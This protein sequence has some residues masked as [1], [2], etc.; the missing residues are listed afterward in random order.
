MRIDDRG[1]VTIEASLALSSLVIVAAAVVGAMATM[2]AAIAAVDIAGAAARAH[3][4]GVA[5]PPPRDD[6]HVS[7]RESHGLV[8][9]V[10]EVDAPLGTMSATAV[11]PVETP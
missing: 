5:A 1:N 10:A 11:F 2:A 4:I 6:A 9:V 8:T 7:V 3:A